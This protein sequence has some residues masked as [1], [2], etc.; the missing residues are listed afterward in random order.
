LWKQ[1]I[2]KTTCADLTGLSSFKKS[3]K[4]T[5]RHR[6]ISASKITGQPGIGRRMSLHVMT[7]G[8]SI[9]VNK[10][11]LAP[12][13][14]PHPAPYRNKEQC[15]TKEQYKVKEQRRRSSSGRRER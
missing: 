11:Q 2:L 9:A 4:A 12:L 8:N 7:L 6:I 5:F 15:K 10:E 14:A 3:N 13:H 1:S